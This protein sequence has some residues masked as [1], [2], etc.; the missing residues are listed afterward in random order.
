MRTLSIAAAL[1]VSVAISIGPPEPSEAQTAAPAPICTPGAAGSAMP[2][3]LAQWAEG[4]RLFDG[5]GDFHRPA[6]T[7]SAEAQKY[8]DQGMRY[9]WAFNHDE[10]T[11][12]F[13]KAA[14]LDP[15]CAIC[16]WGVSLTVGPNYNLPLLAEPRAAVAWDALQ[17]AQH[18][19]ANTSPA[20]RALITALAKRYTSAAPLDPATAGPLL[21]A[22]AAAMK[23]VARQYPDDPDIQVMAAEA[24]MTSNAWK[25]W[26]LD[27]N[28][29]PGTEDIVSTLELVLSKHPT[30][31]GANHYYIHA[32]EASPHPE[33]GIAAAQRLKGM[34]PAAGH[35]EHMPA[36]IYQRIGHYEAAASANR[37][38]IAAD[39][40]YFEQAR[41]PDYYAM[42]TGHNYQFLALS[43]AMQGSK[44]ETLK[45][46]QKSRE[47]MPD[48]MLLAMP[49]ADWYVAE[50]YAGLI[51]FGMWDD[52]LTEP[53]PNPKL[54]GLHGAYLY[55]TASALAAKS[56][57]DLAKTRLGELKAFAGTVA[58]D[59]AGLNSLKDVLAIAILTVQ[60]RIA[61]AE[62]KPDEA[63]S[64]LGEAVAKED[65]L[66]YD[67]PGDWFVPGR[68]LLGAMLLEA[69]RAAE[70][71][72]AYRDDLAR[73]SE[74]GWA[75]FGLARALEAQGKTADAVEARKRSE[76]AWVRADIPLTASAF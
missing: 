45:A 5:L 37:S 65:Q 24:A 76:A 63:I 18:A 6:T 36:H 59:S 9:I 39:L 68:H 53:P 48:E 29:A 52:I 11:R 34:M 2:R 40:I 61:A 14:Q 4:A 73:Y 20:E 67:E 55:A 64:L 72:R 38:G 54:P 49:G 27:G 71:E 22:Y 1:T 70:A 26:S 62:K 25:L 60:A 58:D 44:A 7:K 10:A 16:Y 8:F 12:S 33:R 51:R 66:A 28:A 46:V 30:H 31:A 56:K 19:V 15:E 74:N 42:Y 50:Q 41:P 21:T 57:I 13:A 43:T 47:V 17:Q 3:T 69:N 35:I 32:I 75:L 23:A